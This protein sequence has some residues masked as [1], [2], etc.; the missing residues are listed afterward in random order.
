ME[1]KYVNSSVNVDIEVIFSENCVLFFIFF[2]VIDV[3]IVYIREGMVG[4]F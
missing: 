3:I 1:R 2:L 4:S